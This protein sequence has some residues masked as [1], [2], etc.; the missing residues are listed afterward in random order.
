MHKSEIPE[1]VKGRI[2]GHQCEIYERTGLPKGMIAGTTAE[3]FMVNCG[4]WN[5]GHKLVLVSEVVVPKE[6]R[7]RINV[8]KVF[9]HP[10]SGKEVQLRIEFDDSVPKEV[11]Y[12]IEE[13][14]DILRQLTDH[15]KLFVFTNEGKAFQVSHSANNPF[16]IDLMQLD[17]KCI[18]MHTLYTIIPVVEHFRLKAY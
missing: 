16:E 3:N 12:T 2:D 17:K 10:V 4:G 18:K 6:V 1:I 13:S 7:E 11:N 15:E 8:L 9:R 14:K 5:C